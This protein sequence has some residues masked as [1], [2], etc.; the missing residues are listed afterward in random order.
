M[1]CGVRALVYVV[2]ILRD[3]AIIHVSGTR[4]DGSIADSCSFEVAVADDI[5]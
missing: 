3:V 2:V 4:I 5:R 1:G